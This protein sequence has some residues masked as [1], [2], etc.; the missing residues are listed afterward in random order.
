M[1][2]TRALLTALAEVSSLAT[3]RAELPWRPPD[4]S[5][6]PPPPGDQAE[7]DRRMRG[8]DRQTAAPR[9]DEGR[10]RR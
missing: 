5:A 6:M 8:A 4:P 1:V 10:R 9:D 7:M 3:L 2:P